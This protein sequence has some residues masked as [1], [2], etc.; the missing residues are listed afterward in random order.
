[1]LAVMQ[2]QEDSSFLIWVGYSISQ[3]TRNWRQSTGKTS[4]AILVSRFNII[5]QINRQLAD[6]L[7]NSCKVPTP[8]LRFAFSVC[9]RGEL[10]LTNDLSS[11]HSVIL[12]YCSSYCPGP[13]MEWCTWCLDLWRV[14]CST[15]KWVSSW[16]VEG[17]DS[18][19]ISVWHCTFLV[20]S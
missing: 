17:A 2:R 15:C 20:N 11:S 5:A 3:P 18:Y 19:S 7:I 13:F 6:K 12:R 8:I 9:L 4:I 16:R 10:Q 1:M 14:C